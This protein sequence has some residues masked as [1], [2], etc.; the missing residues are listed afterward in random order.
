MLHLQDWGFRSSAIEHQGLW[1]LWDGMPCCRGIAMP[2][3]SVS[4]NPRKQNYP[5]VKLKALQSF[6]MPNSTASHPRRLASYLRLL[7][8]SSPQSHNPYT[9]KL[10]TLILFACIL[11]ITSWCESF[12]CAMCCLCLCSSCS[13]TSFVCPSSSCSFLS[14]RWSSLICA[15]SCNQ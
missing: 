13:S 7:Y 3:S 14:S 12:R 15:C 2:S 6:Q 10:L 5:N 1:D 4:N 8:G 11:A 9:F